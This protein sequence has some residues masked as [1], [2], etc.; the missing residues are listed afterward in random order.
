VLHQELRRM[1]DVAT[2]ELEARRQEMAQLLGL[3]GQ[4][5]TR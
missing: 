4:A 2:V 3:L 5:Q 1:L